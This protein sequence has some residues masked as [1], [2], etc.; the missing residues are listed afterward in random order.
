MDA[1]CLN[2]VV[3]TCGLFAANQGR[4]RGNLRHLAK[5]L[6]VGK[7]DKVPQVAK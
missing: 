4:K 1:L 7:T 6:I 2:F 5:I 3:A